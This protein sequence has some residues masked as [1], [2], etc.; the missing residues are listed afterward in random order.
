MN[1]AQCND[2][3]CYLGEKVC[4]NLQEECLQK[5]ENPA[6]RNAVTISSELEANYYCQLTRFEEVYKYCEMMGYQK[7]GLAFC[8]GLS[9]EA[10]LI[11]DYFGQKFKVASVCCKNG[12]ISKETFSVPKVKE[13]RYEAV[14]NPV[15]QAMILNK[16]K[17]DLNLIIGLCVGHDILFTQ[18]SEAPVSTLVVKDRVLAH[19]PLGAL[20]SGYYRKKLIR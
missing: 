4:H 16:E 2:K 9:E 1:C 17:T 6:D 19:N 13:G 14:C 12:S 20:Y 15:G 10:K 11:S 5:Y 7:I 3:N 8:F 18:H